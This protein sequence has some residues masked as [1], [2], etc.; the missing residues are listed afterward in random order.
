MAIPGFYNTVGI[1]EHIADSE[2]KFSVLLEQTERSVIEAFGKMCGA[3]LTEKRLTGCHTRVKIAGVI[4]FIGD[5]TWTLTLVMPSD[6][7]EGIATKFAG[8]QIDFESADMADVIGEFVNV[9]AGI[10]CG[11]LEECEIAGQMSLPTVARG[12]A[13]EL[14]KPD[15]LLSHRMYFTA[16]G[17]DFWVDVSAIKT[18]LN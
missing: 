6:S 1:S 16:C 15:H 17:D 8:F 14:M 3:T 12:D 9:V 7:A 2:P 10:A 18:S 11:H 4:S 5:I 13:F